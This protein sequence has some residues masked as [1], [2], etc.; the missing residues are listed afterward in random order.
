MERNARALYSVLSCRP[1]IINCT[2]T[3]RFFNDIVFVCGRW[4]TAGSPHRL[5]WLWLQVLEKWTKE[6]VPYEKGI[7]V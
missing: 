2:S 3:L 4:D 6:Q 7:G 1:M 5:A